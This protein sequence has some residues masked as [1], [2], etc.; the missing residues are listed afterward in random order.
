MNLSGRL[1][2]QLHRRF[3]SSRGKIVQRL[4]QK[5][6][7]LEIEAFVASV[8]TKVNLD[9]SHWT[10]R[11]HFRGTTLVQYPFEQ[12]FRPCI[13]S[14]VG[15]FADPI[16]WTVPTSNG[17]LLLLSFV[18]YS[19]PLYRS[20]F[21]PISLSL[22]VSDSMSPLLS[23]YVF[24]VSSFLIPLPSA[25][26]RSDV[27]GTNS[28]RPSTDRKADSGEALNGHGIRCGTLRY[29]GHGSGSL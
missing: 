5:I 23:H 21:L 8:E 6:H 1:I 14:I 29:D 19:I 17:A 9:E 27:Y 12:R 4:Q 15:R 3:R 11:F 24:G 16:V 22:T 25:S 2:S 13:D 7:S 18:P 28:K 26:S 20:L 10:Q